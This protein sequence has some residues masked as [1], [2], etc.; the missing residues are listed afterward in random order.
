MATGIEIP[1][2]RL[3]SHEAFQ[4]NGDLWKFAQDLTINSHQSNSVH[5]RQRD[6]LTIIS[7][8]IRCRNELKYGRGRNW[9][10]LSIQHGLGEIRDGACLFNG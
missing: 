6:E 1:G 10:L 9:E 7:R 3:V 8:A 4:G 2:L 5:M